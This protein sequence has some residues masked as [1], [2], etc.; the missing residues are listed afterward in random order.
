MWL[1]PVWVWNVKDLYR[2]R[3]VNP[4]VPRR[5][6]WTVRL[7]EREH[8]YAAVVL[9]AQLFGVGADDEAARSDQERAHAD[10]A[11]PGRVPRQRLAGRGADRADADPRHRT[12]AG[13]LRVATVR[14]VQVALMP[15][16]VHGGAGHRHR[17][18]RVAAGALH[19]R[20]VVPAG[21]GGLEPG[22]RVAQ[23]RRRGRAA[24][25]GDDEVPAIRREFDLAQVGVE[26]LH[27]LRF[28]RV[29]VP[30]HERRGRAGDVEHGD[31]RPIDRADLEQCADR[32]EPRAVGGDVEMLDPGTAQPRCG[33]PGVESG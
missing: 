24:G 9:L 25:G 23:L 17:V 18:Q 31:L 2:R 4:A 20:R 27:A 32:H 29:G 3:A 5:P 14:V 15:A 6:Q 21:A 1:T 28:V 26:P 12:R 30:A 7:A 19:P 16:D 11:G 13:A 10:A 22:G 33:E 8:A